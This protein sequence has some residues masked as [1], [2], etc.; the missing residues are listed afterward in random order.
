MPIVQADKITFGAR[1]KGQRK[2]KYG[3]KQEKPKQYKAQGR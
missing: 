2:K 3:P 1:R